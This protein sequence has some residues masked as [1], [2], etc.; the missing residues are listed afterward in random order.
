MKRSG[1]LRLAKG[2]KL[3]FVSTPNVETHL[4]KEKATVA[5]MV[6]ECSLAPRQQS[7][8]KEEGDG[9]HAVHPAASQHPRTQTSTREE[10]DSRALPDAL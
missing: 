3:S 2:N 4:P 1:R 7:V 5:K 9:E 8:G 10:S 6:N